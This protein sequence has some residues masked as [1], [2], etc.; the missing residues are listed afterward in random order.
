MKG[1]QLSQGFPLCCG[2]GFFTGD[3]F[4]MLLIFL[5]QR[6]V[7]RWLLLHVVLELTEAVFHLMKA[8]CI[9]S[10][11]NKKDNINA[12]VFTLLKL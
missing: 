10:T 7:G 5:Q 8:G 12:P 9:D 1:L 3:L 6:V 4:A 11:T 2:T